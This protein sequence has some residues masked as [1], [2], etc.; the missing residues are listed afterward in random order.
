MIQIPENFFKAETRLDFE[1]TETMKRAWAIQLTLLEQVLEIADRHDIKIWLDYGSLLG[2]V[3]HKG[4]IPWDDDIDVS[5]MRSDYMRLI[6]ILEK[7]LP[8]YCRVRSLYTTPDYDQPKAFISNRD[9][10]DLGDEKE[11]TDIY[12]GLPYIAGIDLYPLDFV[13][14]YPEQWELIR[15]IYNAVYDL[16]QRYEK[17][18]QK[19]ELEGYLVQIEELLNVKIQRDSHIK[20]SLWKLAD[21]ICQITTDEESDQVVW[22]PDVSMRTTEM[23]RS[24]S[25]YSE[26]I[27]T[28]FEMLKV[29]IPKGY[30]EILCLCYYKNYMT[31]MN[32]GS[33]HG[34]PFYKVQQ[35]YLDRM[36]SIH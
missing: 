7:E 31:P 35:D 23:R 3:R 2:A 33:A 18:E 28:D 12:Y 25:A 6:F 21:S 9:K 22:Y 24:K 5:L 36:K 13:P 26:T 32:T 16:A 11:I 8:K 17:Y 15:H 30:D 1:I 27:M 14:R 20:N 34:Y 19:G 29:P 10:I 4:Y